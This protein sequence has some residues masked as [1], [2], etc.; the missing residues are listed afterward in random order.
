MSGFGKMGSSYF[1]SYRDPN[2]KKTNEVYEGIPE[3]VKTFTVD[4]RDM[5]KYI[6][7]TV[8]ELD[9]PLNPSAKGARSLNAVSYTHLDVY[10]RQDLNS[11]LFLYSQ[12][13]M[14]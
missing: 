7:G 1:V 13:V 11:M 12:D 3:F 5:L 14:D 8:S 6:I 10:K 2:L 4:D 9:I